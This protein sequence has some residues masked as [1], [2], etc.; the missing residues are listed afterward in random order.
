LASSQSDSRQIIHFASLLPPFPTRPRPSSII[1]SIH[2]SIAPTLKLPLR[3]HRR[4]KS[5]KKT[6]KRESPKRLVRLKKRRKR[7]RRRSPRT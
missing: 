1:T 7:R 6:R 2:T 5:K 3:P 4:N